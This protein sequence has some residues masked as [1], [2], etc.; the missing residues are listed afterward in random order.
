MA[1]QEHLTCL[2]RIAGHLHVHFGD[3]RAG[4]IED[5]Q[6]APLRLILHTAGHAVRAE[7]HGG[8]IGHF[9]EFLDEHRADRAQPIDDVFIVNDLVTH[10]DR[11]TEQIDRPFDDVDRAIHARTKSTWIGQ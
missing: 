6:F 2:A 11:R 10:V 3:E 7:D 5:L 8:G 1:D 4:R 9:V